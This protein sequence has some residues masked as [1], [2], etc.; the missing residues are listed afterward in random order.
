M[1]PLTCILA[2][3]GVGIALPEFD[4]LASG[5][6]PLFFPGGPD[7]ARSVLSTITT[8]MISVTG[9]V[10]SITLVVLQLASSQFTPR[11]IGQ[12]LESRTTQA[13]LGSFIA[14][15]VFSLT[16]LRAVEGDYQGGMFVPQISV[17]AAYVLVLSS[18]GFF[19]AFIHH[20]TTSIQVSQVISRVGDRT[21]S[22]VEG[23]Y[24][25]LAEV[26]DDHATWSP[27][28]G[29]TG[30]SVVLDE[31]HGHVVG[32]DQP[33]LVKLAQDAGG[34]IQLEMAVGQFLIG[35]QPLA[36]TWGTALDADQVR[37]LNKAVRLASERHLDQDPA[38]GVRQLVDIAER[39]LSPGIND[40]TTAAQAL[41][42]LHRILRF[43]VQRGELNPLFVDRD[44]FVRVVHRPPT[45]SEL[46]RLALEEVAHYGGDSIQIPAKLQRVLD[47]LASCARPEHRGAI[48]RARA[49]VESTCEGGEG[50]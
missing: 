7:G 37:R 42:E 2:A 45:V 19:L 14:S 35:G 29:E 20:I 22:L 33:A 44:G 8:A 46:L 6:L 40:P 13:T 25:E 31:R 18:V 16:V 36:L 23:L 26:P 34:V 10:F 48:Q 21:V 4:R 49:L 39:A 9:L 15:F 38:F 50:A 1:L 41:D 43:V 17:S 24:R 28:P 30:A 3:L 47:D 11:V 27:P 32:I 12:F 5:Q